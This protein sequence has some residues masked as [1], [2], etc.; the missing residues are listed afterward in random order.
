MLAGWRAW[1]L[2][3]GSVGLALLLRLIL[4]PLWADRLP[5]VPFFFAV[6]FVTHF[7]EPGPSLFAIIAGFLL[8]A[9]FFAAPRHSL[10]LSNP[11]DRYNTVF[12]FVLSFGV[13][14][15]A[16]RTRRAQAR[17]RVARMALGRLAAIIESSDDAIIGRSL[18]GKIVSRNAGARKL[19]GYTEA[20]AVGQPLTFLVPPERGKEL[21]PLLERVAR[22]EHLRHLETTRRRKDGEFVEVSLS[23]SPVLNSAGKIVGVSTIG[24]FRNG[25][26]RSVRKSVWWKSRAGFWAK[27]RP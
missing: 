3:A 1:G 27:S 7:T 14:F 19:Y 13:L 18:D 15:L 8:G 23:V 11:L 22:G 20:E 16:R 4:D 12:Y 2:A 25:S 26:A 6:I 24:T 5:Y 21:M 10:L 17:E 9:W